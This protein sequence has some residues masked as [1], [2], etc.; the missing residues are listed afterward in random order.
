MKSVRHVLKVK[1]DDDFKAIIISN[2]PLGRDIMDVLER[3]Y[4]L[5]S[6]EIP[7]SVNL[8]QFKSDLCNCPKKR[9]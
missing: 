5:D 1:A 4:E 2:E 8:N 3:E 7:N 6:I 9:K